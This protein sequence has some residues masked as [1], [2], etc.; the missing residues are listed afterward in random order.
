MK[1]LIC[2]LLAASTC[3]CMAQA[4]GPAIVHTSNEL[5]FSIALPSDWEVMDTSALA[6]EKAREQAKTED[7]KKGLGC[8]QVGLTARHGSPPSIITEVALPFA[9]YGQQV[10]ASDLPGFASGVSA[11]LRQNL[12]LGEPVTG[13]YVV[14][15]H[16]FWV[17]RVAG[18]VKGQ[19]D[20]QYTIEIA[21]SLT[22]KAAVCWMAM[23][24]DKTALATFERSPVT[25][26]GEGP[27]ALVPETVF[28][29][30]PS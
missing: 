1:S 3:I 25:L 18:T 21:C 28:E 29:K 11:G 2:I 16:S 24:S 8:V 23:A 17:E 14:G 12:D 10:S 6:Q 4:Q 20:A 26:D 30:K 5:G 9:C 13:T 27:A 19:P 15:S 22:K 7:D